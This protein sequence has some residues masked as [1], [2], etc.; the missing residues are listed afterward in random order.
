MEES[1]NFSA[2]GD[3]T[4]QPTIYIDAF[5]NEELA[6]KKAFQKGNTGYGHR[7][8]DGW[9]IRGTAGIVLD[10]SQPEAEEE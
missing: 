8:D 1:D 4:Y 5:G 9:C 7:Q 6:F 3:S 10:P 2:L